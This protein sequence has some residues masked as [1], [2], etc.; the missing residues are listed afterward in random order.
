MSDSQVTTGCEWFGLTLSLIQ[1]MSLVAIEVTAGIATI[2]PV[3][4]DNVSVTPLDRSKFLSLLSC[5][6]FVMLQ[7]AHVPNF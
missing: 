4:L 2:T 5:L 3:A 1:A 6:F 7:D